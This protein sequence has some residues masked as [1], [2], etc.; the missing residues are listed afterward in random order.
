MQQ[1][2]TWVVTHSK[3]DSNLHGHRLAISGKQCRLWILFISQHL[4]PESS[5]RT[6]RSSRISSMAYQQRPTLLQVGPQSDQGRMPMSPEGCHHLP[7]HSCNSR[8]LLATA[9]NHQG[10]ERTA[11]IPSLRAWVHGRQDGGLV[12]YGF[13]FGE[14][15]PRNSLRVLRRALGAGDGEKQAVAKVLDIVPQHVE[16]HVVCSSV[17]IANISLFFYPLGRPRDGPQCLSRSTLD[18]QPCSVSTSWRSTV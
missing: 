15:H 11:T 10:L 6:F 9:T 16:L 1:I 7:T 12:V 2:G 17:N 14:D 13:S 5:I 3:A 18:C 4:N 8:L